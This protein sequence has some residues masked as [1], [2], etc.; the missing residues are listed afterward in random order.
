MLMNISVSTVHVRRYSYCVSAPMKDFELESI[1][2]I[3]IRLFFRLKGDIKDSINKELEV[4]MFLE[5]AMTYI[6]RPNKVSF[7]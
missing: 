5:T 4:L 7:S 6:D 1:E 3:S 2:A